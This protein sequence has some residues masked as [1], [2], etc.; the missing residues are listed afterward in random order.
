MLLYALH[1]V[2]DVRLPNR[3]SDPLYNVFIIYSYYSLL[4]KIFARDW[5]TFHLVFTECSKGRG[6]KSGRKRRREARE[7]TEQ[8]REIEKAL[9]ARE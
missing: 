1:R 8:K 5:R 9:R 3:V 6:N 7:E 4:Y 2:S